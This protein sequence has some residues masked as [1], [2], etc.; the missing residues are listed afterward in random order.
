MENQ[1]NATYQWLTKG[2]N[3]TGGLPTR[4]DNALNTCPTRIDLEDLFLE[5][6]FGKRFWMG[7]IPKLVDLDNEGSALQIIHPHP[8]P[9]PLK[10]IKGVESMEKGRRNLAIKLHRYS[11]ELWSEV[12]GKEDRRMIASNFH[13]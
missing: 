7:S 12:G 6:G 3:A 2:F 5:R 1:V 11:V 13:M 4:V 9:Y 8:Y 10:L